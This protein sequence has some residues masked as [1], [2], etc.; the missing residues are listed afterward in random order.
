MHTHKVE[1]VEQNVYKTFLCPQGLQELSAPGD[2]R[3]KEN[4]WYPR[5]AAPPSSSQ[6]TRPLS[7]FWRWGWKIHTGHFEDIC[8]LELANCQDEAWPEMTQASP[9]VP[10]FIPPSLLLM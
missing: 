8:K 7:T 5:E 6:P 2:Q 3:R 9:S 1:N 4:T 10:L